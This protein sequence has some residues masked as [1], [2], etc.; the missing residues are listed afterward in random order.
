MHSDPSRRASLFGWFY[1]L[2]APVEALSLAVGAALTIRFS[3]AGIFLASGYVE[4]L[5][6]LT[7]ITFFSFSRNRVTLTQ[8]RRRPNFERKNAAARSRDE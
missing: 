4:I 8:V 7:A 2:Q 1:G 5:V 6:A 3:A